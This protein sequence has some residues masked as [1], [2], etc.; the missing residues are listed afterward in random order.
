MICQYHA[1]GPKNP[2]HASGVYVFADLHTPSNSPRHAVAGPFADGYGA[3]LWILQHQEAGL[4]DAQR[5]AWAALVEQL[6]GLTH[7]LGLELELL[8]RV[9]R[10]RTVAQLEKYLPR[11]WRPAVDRKMLASG[12]AA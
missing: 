1:Q 11:V 10:G 4:S 12:E 7:D 6:G 3:R 8:D 2:D 9:I 5:A